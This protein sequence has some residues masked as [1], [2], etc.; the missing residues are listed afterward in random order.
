[1]TAQRYSSAIFVAMMQMNKLTWTPFGPIVKILN[2]F[3]SAVGADLSRP[4]PIDRPHWSLTN[5]YGSVCEEPVS[6]AGD[7]NACFECILC[8]MNHPTSATGTR[9]ML[10]TTSQISKVANPWPNPRAT[11]HESC[12]TCPTLQGVEEGGGGVT[13]AIGCRSIVII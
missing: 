4:S 12:S 11:D 6:I 5:Y 9:Y 2:N 13:G 7:V 10:K 1:M 8:Q 3:R